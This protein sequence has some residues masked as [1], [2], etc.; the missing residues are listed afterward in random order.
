MCWFPDDPMADTGTF[1]EDKML[2]LDMTWTCE[3]T[4][5][6]YTVY[7]TGEITVGNCGTSSFY[8]PH[9]FAV[10]KINHDIKLIAIAVL[11]KE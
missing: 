5:S 9:R 4:Y 8:G 2:P 7:S 11:F 10:D 3:I 6:S 1:C